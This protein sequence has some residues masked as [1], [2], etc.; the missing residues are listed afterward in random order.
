MSSRQPNSLYWN[1]YVQYEH[2]LGNNARI[3]M[4][5]NVWRK[6]DPEQRAALLTQAEY[7]LERGM[8]CRGDCADGGENQTIIYTRKYAQS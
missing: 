1:F 6:M 3:Q 7:Y 4:M 5:Y 2:L 8:S